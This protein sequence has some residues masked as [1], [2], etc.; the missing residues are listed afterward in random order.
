MSKKQV[1]GAV[2][3]KKA[4]KP[5]AVLVIVL[6]ITAI[7]GFFLVRAAVD[8]ESSKILKQAMNNARTAE[9]SLSKEALLALN[10]SRSDVAKPEYDLLK[11]SLVK[12]VQ[13]NSEFAFAY[14]Y[15]QRDGKI[16]FAVD[17]EPVYSP[18]YS[19]PGQEYTEADEEAKLPFSSGE[20][21]VTK[22]STDRWG[23]WISMLV[24]MKD[25]LLGRTFAV[26]GMDYPA[27]LWNQRMTSHAIQGAVYVAALMLL[28]SAF[29]LITRKNSQL[30][31]SQVLIKQSDDKN[32]ILTNVTIEGIVIQKNGLIADMNPSMHKMFGY[33]REEM[34]GKDISIYFTD[35]DSPVVKENI[36]S[37]STQPYTVNAVRKNG[38][39]FI[40]TIEGIVCQMN[41]ETVRASSVRDVTK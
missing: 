5:L 25:N 40:V 38:E 14:I 6:F 1:P 39:T 41:G 13:V 7:S 31:K 30:R 32:R 22:P 12:I 24:P 3:D 9:A 36:S 19:P 10:I 23:T 20:P 16:Y 4:N 37:N 35:E 34:I 29:Y 18:D 8:S 15:T 33:E 2:S 21:L 11:K 26:F 17:S 27:E 28:I